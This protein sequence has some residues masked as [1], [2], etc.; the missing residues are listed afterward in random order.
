[1]KKIQYIAVIFGFAVSA[2]GYLI[3]DITTSEF[4]AFGIFYTIGAIVT[5]C[6][7]DII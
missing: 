7:K 5:A 6:Q 4:I 1:M 3:G 2:I